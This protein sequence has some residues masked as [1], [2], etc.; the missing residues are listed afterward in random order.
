[1]KILFR[2][3]ILY[4]R[5]RLLYYQLKLRILS[6]GV[7]PEHLKYVKQLAQRRVE[8]KAAQKRK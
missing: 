1:M 7:D 4:H 3:R 6:R 2:T 8:W 5:L